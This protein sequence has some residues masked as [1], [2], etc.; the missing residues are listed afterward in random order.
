MTLPVLQLDAELECPAGLQEFQAGL[1][2]YPGEMLAR[3]YAKL[4]YQG[5]RGENVNLI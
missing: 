4:V 2:A 3:L 1:L 5:G